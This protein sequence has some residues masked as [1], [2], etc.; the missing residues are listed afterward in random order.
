VATELALPTFDEASSDQPARPGARQMLGLVR[1]SLR[2]SWIAAPRELVLCAV[3]QVAV[4]GTV[5]VQLLL[6]RTVLAAVVDGRRTQDLGDLMPTIL[7]L[8]LV[9]ALSA[10]ATAVLGERQRVLAALVERH[11]QD[12][13]LDV[14][15]QVPLADFENPSFHDRLRRASVNGG[16]RSWQVALALVSLF[17][18]VA[19]VVPMAFV[20]LRIE[21]IILPAVV[22]AYVPMQLATTRN[23][24]A[25]YQFTFWQTT[26][27]RERAYLGALLNAPVAAKE[28]RLFASGPWIRSRYDALYDQRIHELRKLAVR[29]TRRALWATAWSSAITVGGIALLVH[30]ALSGRLAP[31]EAGIAGVALQ[32]VG[33]RM[34]SLGTSAGSLHECAL[35]LDDVIGFVTK[36]AGE[37]EP[38]AGVP[39]PSTFER[40]RVE[41]LD[42]TYPGTDRPVLRDINLEVGKAEVVAI[43]GSNGS[44]KTTLAKLLCG[45]YTPT[46]GQVLWD[47][48]DAAAFDPTSLRRRMAASFQDFVHYD[49]SGR[50]NIGLGD[51]DRMD[52][53]DG[54]RLAA[55]AAGAHEAL[56]RLPEGYETRL[57]RAYE[58]GADLS[59][60]QWQR[61]ALARAFLRDAPFLVL[62]EPTASLD[63]HAERELFEAMRQLQRDRAVLLISHRFSSVRSADR[64]Y[65]LEQGEV[66]ESGTHQALM[67]RGGRYAEMFTLQ[68]AAYLVEDGPPGEGS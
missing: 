29:R 30:W 35:F 54:I 22:L 37:D 1:R 31:E 25:S 38:V 53:V 46:G 28:I 36:P 40:L 23:G 33:S 12:R 10:G 15:A 8:A 20:L 68:A 62:D 55:E 52:D 21:P 24:R 41:H 16:E 7:G 60:G 57:S 65:V 47:D 44:G 49:L 18:A 61:V 67:E 27:D 14:V 17:S 58:S 11:V 66:I 9:T 51:P 56:V 59:I 63:P 26:A 3:L 42:F 64:I 39:A 34:R 48:V 32:Q 6:G 50:V 43:V 19:M 4:A 13:I 2:L 5:L 45:L